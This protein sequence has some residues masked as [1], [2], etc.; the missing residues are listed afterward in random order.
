MIYKI[1][2]VLLRWMG[3]DAKRGNARLRKLL[4]WF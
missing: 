2:C 3:G 4:E 1:F